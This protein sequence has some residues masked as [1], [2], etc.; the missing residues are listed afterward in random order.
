MQQLDKVEELP[1]IEVKLRPTMLNPPYTQCF[2]SL[3]N[4]MTSADTEILFSKDETQLASS[5]PSGKI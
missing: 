3:Y 1:A 4:H 5:K 2:T